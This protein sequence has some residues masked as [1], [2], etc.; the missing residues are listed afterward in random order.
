MSSKYTTFYAVH[1]LIY[2]IQNPAQSSSLVKLGNGHKEALRTL[3]EIFRKSSPPV[4]PSRVT[5]REVVQDKINEVN[6]EI[7]QTKSAS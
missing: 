5:V 4:I 6:Q 2:A 3:A 7:A 1:D